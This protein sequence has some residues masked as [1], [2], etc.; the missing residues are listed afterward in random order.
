MSQISVRIEG[1]HLAF[2]C[3]IS[4]RQELIFP[5]KDSNPKFNNLEVKMVPLA[6]F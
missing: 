4:F 1:K 5:F 3:P 2:S 6:V